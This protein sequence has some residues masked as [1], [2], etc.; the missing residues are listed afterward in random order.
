MMGSNAYD[1]DR[2]KWGRSAITDEI[3][4]KII[5]MIEASVSL[6]KVDLLAEDLLEIMADARN[7]PDGFI[8]A[9]QHLGL[10]IKDYRPDEEAT[11]EG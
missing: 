10:L 1:P 9:N 5:I 3:R 11:E 8:A 7:L 6:G 4:D 2:H